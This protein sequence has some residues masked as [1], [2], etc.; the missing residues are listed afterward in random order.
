MIALF[1]GPGIGLVAFLRKY[2]SNVHQMLTPAGPTECDNFVSFIH[3][4]AKSRI[5]LLMIPRIKEDRDILLLV[6][7]RGSE[8]QAEARISTAKR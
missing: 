5:A 1:Y 3:S 4:F 6:G 7:Q 2:E 8:K